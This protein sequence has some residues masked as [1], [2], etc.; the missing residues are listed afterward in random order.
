[1]TGWTSNPDYTHEHTPIVN[2]GVAIAEIERTNKVPTH[3]PYTNPDT[4]I[5]YSCK[6]GEVFDPG[7]KSFAA[8]N[9]AAS[10]TGWIISWCKNGQGYDAF[11]PK[12]AEKE[13]CE[14]AG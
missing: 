12:C 7:T 4:Q 2:V 9:N 6:C 13:W 8:L 3:D 14:N 11:C 5:Y 10:H 1:M